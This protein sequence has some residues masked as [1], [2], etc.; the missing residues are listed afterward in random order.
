MVSDSDFRSGYCTGSHSG[1]P[2]RIAL[3]AI[4]FS[5]A[6]TLF[7]QAP[8]PAAP[9]PPAKIEAMA[10]LAGYW[11]GEGL[12]GKIEDTW[13]PPRDG[14]I[15]GAFRLTKADGK[16]FYELFAVEEF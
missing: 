3:A 14:V 10:W 5:T 13:M 2:M 8:A 15:L 12:G 1:G 16:G 6:T 7:A 9:P 11:E 4:V